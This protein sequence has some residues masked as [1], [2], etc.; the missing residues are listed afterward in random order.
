MPISVKRDIKRRYGFGKNFSLKDTP[1][2]VPLGNTPIRVF[3]D[4]GGSYLEF[5]RPAMADQ[6]WTD[7]YKS[8]DIFN[9]ERDL[10]KSI[11]KKFN[12]K[13]SEEQ[14]FNELW[15]IAND[16][17][18]FKGDKE[19]TLESALDRAYKHAAKI[20]G[21]GQVNQK[22]FSRVVDRADGNFVIFSDHHMTALNSS[23]DYFKN[24]NYGLYLEVLEHYATTDFC[25]VENGDVEECIIYQPTLTDAQLRNS[26]APG[27]GKF[28][29]TL[30]DDKWSDFLTTRYNQRLKNLNNIIR[31]FQDYYELL[32]TR[33]IS[34]N[35][36]VK[37]TGNHD[38]YLDEVHERELRDRIQDELGIS[39]RDILRISRSGEIKYVVL[40]GHQFDAVCIQHGA[41]SYAKSLGEVF[42]EC[43][44][45]AF[46]GPDRAW[47][48]QDT[49]RWFIGNSYRNILAREKPGTYQSGTK[50][51]ADLVL[52]NVGRIKADSKD[53]VETLLGHEIAWEYF[54]ND[55]GF[56]AL[57][58]EVWTGEE[59]YK[60]R[61]M[62][63]I[64][65][66]ERYASEFLDLQTPPDFSR[67]I[68]KIVVGHTHEPRQNAINPAQSGSSV[69]YYLNSGSAG[70]YENL[71]W[72]VEI[73][74]NEDRICSWSKMDG[75]LKKIIW[76][77]ESDKLVHDSVQWINI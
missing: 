50:G 25:L 16:A 20:A 47:T 21:G 67:P 8:W 32:R 22:T 65:L 31:E 64:K 69:Y 51:V 5:V 19:D 26:Q 34:R 68:P 75:K 4:Y 42:S 48:L 53:F 13:T 27:K 2:Y 46:Q 23:L 60:L 70:R 55:D 77:S 61:H 76:R 38:T 11:A 12:L 37:L 45:W 74:G 9:A 73:V 7:F 3:G 41:I 62:N 44:G 35:K 33:F 58:L 36:Y 17:H 43:L 15:T 14:I 72:C 49:K 1:L 52:E 57:T 54:E 18:S 29:I 6:N 39:V 28:P 10:T 30:G 40:H 63:E 56:N 66:C 59:L 71:I 24:F